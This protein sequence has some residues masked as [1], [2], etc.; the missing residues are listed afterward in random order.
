M[1]LR[2]CLSLFAVATCSSLLSSSQPWP[3]SSRFDALAPKST[4]FLTPTLFPKTTPALRLSKRPGPSTS[5]A[6]SFQAAYLRKKG[7]T[8]S[9]FAT[10]ASSQTSPQTETEEDSSLGYFCP[11]HALCG[12]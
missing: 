5:S 12:V 7:V 8:T 10:A 3:A 11:A 4:A 6:A 2:S 9:V 1:A